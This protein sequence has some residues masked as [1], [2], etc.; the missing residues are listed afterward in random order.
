[1]AEVDWPTLRNAAFAAR[2]RAYAPYSRYPVGAALLASSGAIYPGCNVENAAYSVCMC[3][4]R[5]ALYAAVAAGERSFSALAVVADSA[6]PV[7]PCG[8]CRQAL[9]ELA[10]DMPVLLTN[11][12]GVE[13]H[14]TARALLPD[15]FEA[16][17]L[18]QI[19]P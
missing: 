3:A 1:M 6:R 10:P 13:R 7:P 14:T 9:L 16:H 4:E 15:G 5:T 8:M 17:D 18:R 11:V 19:E 12:A 2:E